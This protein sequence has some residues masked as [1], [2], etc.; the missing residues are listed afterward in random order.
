MRELGE[1]VYAPQ[2]ASF[3]FGER[4]RDQSTLG[5]AYEGRWKG[6]GEA[7]LGLQR[8]DYEKRIDQPRLAQSATRDR[9]W[10]VN[11]TLAAHLSE[12]LA[13][14]AGYTR[15]LEESGIAPDDAL[16]RNAALPAIRTRQMDGGVRWDIAP[17]LKLLAG[18]F[19]VEKPYFATDDR[20]VFTTLGEVRHRGVELSLAGTPVDALSVVAGAV[21]M[22]PR[23]TGEA[24]TLGRVDEKPVGQTAR[25]LRANIEFRPP[26]TPGFSLDAAIANFGARTASRDGR[27]EVPGYTLIDIGA[28]YR[29]KMAS[30]PMTL[31]VQLANVTDVFTWYVNGNNSFGLSDGRR[32]TAR[33]AADRY[34]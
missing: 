9:P 28:R 32:F 27:S 6:A 12:S 24:V 4:T 7:T 13:L 2:P 26:M 20:N 3:S 25:T 18:V 33:L 5:L 29:F 14:Y 30:T 34:L 8:T 22:Q 19:N 1:A 10:L 11:A 31:R 17:Q 21:L 15:G 16:N 23:V